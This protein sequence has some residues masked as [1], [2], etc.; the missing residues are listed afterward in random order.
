MR[1]RIQADHYAQLA[2]TIFFPVYPVIAHQIL[3]KADIDQGSCLEVGCGPGYLAIALATLS[4]LAVYPMDKSRPMLSIAR[5]NIDRYFL[6]RRVCP[7]YGYSHAI[8]FDDESMD[9]VVSRDS[10]FFWDDLAKGFADCRR[11]LKPGRMAW[12]GGGFGNARLRDEIISRMRQDDPVWEQE[13]RKNFAHCSPRKVKT[14][15]SAAGISEYDLIQ[16]D[17]GFWIC[18]TR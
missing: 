9:L 17:S 11:V 10:F 7:V 2:K 18:F 13:R 3:K 6:G 8:P 5:E 14:A 16:D 1:N 4:D 15:L 12:I